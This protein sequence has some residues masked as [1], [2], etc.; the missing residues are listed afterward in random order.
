MNKFDF[1]QQQGWPGS[2][3]TFSWLQG[4]L[5]QLEQVSGLGGYNYIL[6]GCNEVGGTVTDGWVVINGEIL[7]FTGGP[8]QLNVIV[9]DTVHTRAFFGGAHFPY[10][11]TRQATFG[12]GAGEIA[13]GDLHRTP[14]TGLV[15][16]FNALKAAYDAH[17]H[18]YMGLTSKPAGYIT[19]IGT[20]NIGDVGGL[21][22]PNDSIIT[23][24]IP[25]QGA[26]PYLVTGS[27]VGQSADLNN[28]NDIM[29]IVGTKLNT[30]F[31]LAIREMSAQVQNVRFEYAII[32][33]H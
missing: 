30:S 26:T 11:H 31:K 10:F 4:M 24:T 9:V 21:P 23:V 22:T 15:Q 14:V 2:V 18:S 19:H 12:S 29:W 1:S 13:W 33:A 6:S 27:M 28:D 5:Q 7:P 8:P 17:N 20:L 3:E 25:D 32:K 16:A